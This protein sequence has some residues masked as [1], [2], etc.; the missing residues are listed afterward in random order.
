MPL[1]PQI[2]DRAPAH[3]VRIVVGALLA[4]ARKHADRLSGPSD[5]EALHDFRVSVRRL[6][7]TL[8][9]WRTLLR[10]SVGDKD[11]RRLRRVGRETSEARNA[12]VLAAWVGE[13]A[14]TLPPAHRA[15]ADW[16]VA[17]L[18][19]EVQGWDLSRSVK[20]FRDA[21]DNL[22][23][24]LEHHGPTAST[25][26]FAGAVAGRIREQAT[27]L[28]ASLS[29]VETDDDAS[30]AHRARIAGKRLRYVLEPIRGT[31]GIEA[32]RAL[33]EL[34]RLQDLLGDLNDAHLAAA[35]VRE[36]RHEAKAERV[37]AGR[38]RLLV[39]LRPG[40]RALERLADKRA[41]HLFSRLRAEVLATRGAAVI[42]P[43]LGVA[44]ALEARTRGS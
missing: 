35:A 39:G 36:A 31:P 18:A 26:T 30:L 9:A 8:R 28:K 10:K 11:L 14:V 40:L 27:S 43:A 4:E 1:P 22:S 15:A 6:R 13:I 7:S 19:Q 38:G 29:R 33:K 42:E 41:D 44:A 2:L 12:Q 25:G 24:R 17:R 21:A 20:R 37:R 23:R 3:G 34:R 16:L 5:A 32:G